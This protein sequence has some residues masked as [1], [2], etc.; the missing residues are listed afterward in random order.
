MLFVSP[1]GQNRSG[2]FDVVYISRDRRN[3]SVK[4]KKASLFREKNLKSIESPEALNDYLQVTSPG[5]WI[6]LAAVIAFLVG[7]VSWGIWG[8]IDSKVSAAVIAEGGESFCLV[9]QEALGAVIRGQTVAVEGTDYALAPETLAPETITEETNVY[10]LLAGK[11]KYGDIVYR[12]PLGEELE[13]GV[14]AGMIVTETI[15]PA[16]LLFN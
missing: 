16:E 2:D 12:I 9:P 8:T 14:Y 1:H 15:S 4:E 6:V 7:A 10:W 11:M 13:E 5:V 3:K